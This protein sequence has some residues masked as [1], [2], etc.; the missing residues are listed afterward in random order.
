M[1]QLNLP[2][3]LILRRNTMKIRAVIWNAL[4]Q[5]AIVSELWT[6]GLN[7]NRSKWRSPF[8]NNTARYSIQDISNGIWTDDTHVVGKTHASPPPFTSSISKLPLLS[9]A[10]H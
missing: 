6:Q 9:L 10:Q 8:H 5:S 4:W 3:C 7:M 1:H 2:A